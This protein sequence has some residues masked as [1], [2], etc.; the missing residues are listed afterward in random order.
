M[1]YCRFHNTVKDLEDCWEHW[2]N[3]L[4]EEE[5]IAKKRMI[6]I[7]KQIVEQEELEDDD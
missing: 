3:E 5:Y 1:S 4:S 7:A 2:D 6:Y